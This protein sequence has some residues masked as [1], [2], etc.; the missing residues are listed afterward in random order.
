MITFMDCSAHVG[1]YSQILL[2][3]DLTLM[4]KLSARMWSNALVPLSPRQRQSSSPFPLSE[5]IALSV[6]LAVKWTSNSSEGCC[7]DQAQVKLVLWS[8]KC[9]AVRSVSWSNG[10]VFWK[11]S[12]P[13][14]F[15]N[16][17]NGWGRSPLLSPLRLSP[18][19]GVAG[20]TVLPGS[21]LSW[22]ARYFKT[23]RAW[24]S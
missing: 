2:V 16:E 1:C 18:L 4:S 7:A 12:F 17:E 19:A 23:I 22:V 10:D 14:S 21:G 13:K 6:S 15:L 11:L 9:A 24:S 20:G 8:L 5:V 3:W